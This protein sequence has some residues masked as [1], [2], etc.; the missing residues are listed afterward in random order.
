MVDQKLLEIL[1]CPKCK[2]ELEYKPLPDDDRRG[3]LVCHVCE[4][5]YSV[6]DNI[7][8]MIIEQAKPYTKEST[9]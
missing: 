5:A 2:N 6:Q 1:V 9:G 7:P 8:I 4:L 3:E